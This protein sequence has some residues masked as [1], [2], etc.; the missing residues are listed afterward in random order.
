MANQTVSKYLSIGT[1]FG[2]TF[3]PFELPLDS[4]FKVVPTYVHK[5]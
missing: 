4:T 3:D 5:K 1:T 2:T